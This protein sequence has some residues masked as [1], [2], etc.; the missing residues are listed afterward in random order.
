MK[1]ILIY[2][3]NGYTGRLILEEAFSRNLSITIAG[4]NELEILK[5]SEEYNVACEVFALDEREKMLRVLNSHDVVIHC[6]GPFMYTPCLW[7][8]LVWKQA[9]IISTLQ[10]ST[11]SLNRFMIWMRLLK[12]RMLC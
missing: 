2:G 3:A 9:P 7:L 10:V 1:K 11:K 8:R 6:A 12:Q 5:L 4:R